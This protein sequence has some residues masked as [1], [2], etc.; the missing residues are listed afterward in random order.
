M[1]ISLGDAMVSGNDFSTLTWEDAVQTVTVVMTLDVEQLKEY[2]LAGQ[3]AERHVLANLIPSSG[4][5]IGLMTSCNHTSS[6]TIDKSGI[7]ACIQGVQPYGVGMG[8]D[9]GI[10]FEDETFWNNAATAA[11][12]LTKNTVTGATATFTLFDS[13]GVTLQNCGG[14]WN[15]SFKGISPAFT[16]VEFDKAVTSA[17]VFGQDV[18]EG[19]F[20]YLAEA[21][22]RTELG[23]PV[24]PEPT[25]ATLSLL[26]LAGLAARRRRASR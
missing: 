10:G 5:Q 8:N 15:S 26:A 16:S 4:I 22:A 20:G 13:N 23:L 1:G 2:M 6:N 17:Y 24:I 3:P 18:A 12:T 7:Y 25:T 21:A 11:I 14:E 9:A 19:D